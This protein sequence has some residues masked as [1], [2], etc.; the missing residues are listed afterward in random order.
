M[1]RVIATNL[2]LIDL[3]NYLMREIV[4]CKLYHP[5]VLTRNYNN[6][7]TGSHLCGLLYPKSNWYS[8]YDFLTLV[9]KTRT[10]IA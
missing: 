4:T 1:A 5:I 6:R 2:K 3:P 10:N 8:R 7:E 9:P